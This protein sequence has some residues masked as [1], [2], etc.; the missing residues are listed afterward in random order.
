MM[1][2]AIAVR[3][4]SY[5]PSRPIVEG[6]TL[7]DCRH[8]ATFPALSGYEPHHAGHEIEWCLDQGWNCLPGARPH[9]SPQPPS[10]CFAKSP[11]NPKEPVPERRQDP[12]LPFNVEGTT[13][14][15]GPGEEGHHELP[16]P[17]GHLNTNV[18][19]RVR[20]RMLG[21]LEEQA[22]IHRCRRWCR[23]TL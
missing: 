9:C 1:L 18:S 21:G 8:C 23:A 6:L 13:C 20:G 2:T 16:L 7:P 4:L 3:F 11:V 19:A 15:H 12:V 14:V 22:G 5:A 10:S 17:P